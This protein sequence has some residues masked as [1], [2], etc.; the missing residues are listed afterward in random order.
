MTPEKVK[1][2]LELCTR[3]EKQ[4][5]L[6]DPEPYALAMADITAA[7]T[8]IELRGLLMQAM[9]GGRF[10]AI[11]QALDTSKFWKG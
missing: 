2:L 3:A 1:Q 9:K 5:G 8:P 4:R 7:L 10:D 11:K 6:D